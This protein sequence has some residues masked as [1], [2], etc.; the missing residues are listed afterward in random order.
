M[1]AVKRTRKRRR[2]F[3]T[4]RNGCANRVEQKRR[5]AYGADERD[6]HIGTHRTNRKRQERWAD[7]REG[8]DKNRWVKRQDM[9]HEG[10][11]E[12]RSGKYRRKIQG[13]QTSG[14]GRQECRH[15]W[16]GN[17]TG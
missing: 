13:T 3:I 11:A 8:A 12:E 1:G 7:E 10:R 9:S 17:V 6:T 2:K 4:K 5:E 14:M 15:E 16:V